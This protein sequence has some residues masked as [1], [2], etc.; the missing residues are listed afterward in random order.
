[1]ITFSI[2]N[3]GILYYNGRKI[4]HYYDKLLFIVI[5]TMIYFFV[6]LV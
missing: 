5:S 6:P 4:C 3:F 2:Y 1:M